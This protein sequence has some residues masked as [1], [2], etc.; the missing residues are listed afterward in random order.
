MITPFAAGLAVFVVLA[1]TVVVMDPWQLGAVFIMGMM[2]LAFLTVGARAGSDPRHPSAID[3]GLSLASLVTGIFFAFTTPETVERISLL[4]PLSFWQTIFGT[5]V[6]V[7][8][9]EITRRNT[10]L[11]ITVLVLLFVADNLVGQMIG[12]RLGQG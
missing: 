5:L 2:T 7:L 9:I 4:F 6:F 3:W 10:G 11:G 12:G 1:A 8:T